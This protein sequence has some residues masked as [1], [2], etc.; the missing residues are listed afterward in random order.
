MTSDL[1]AIGEAMAEIR[2][3][4]EAGFA[5]SYAG[6]TLNTAIYCARCLPESKSTAYLTRIGTDPLS[7]SFIETAE[8]EGLVSDFIETDPDHNIGIY[9]VSTDATGERSFSYWRNDS[10]A[11]QLGKTDRITQS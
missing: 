11:R 9:A 10:A 1:L 5:I 3:S 6:D 2:R 7:K 8:K 4:P